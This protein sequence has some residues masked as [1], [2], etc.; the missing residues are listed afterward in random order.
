MFQLTVVRAEGRDWTVG[1]ALGGRERANVSHVA[2]PLTGALSSAPLLSSP[3]ERNLVKEVFR[4]ML[5]ES[6]I[7]VFAVFLEVLV[8]YINVYQEDLNGWLF[9]LLLRL[10]HKQGTDMLSSVHR[11][12]DKTLE[13]IR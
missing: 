2:S 6:H 1:A 12:L 4:R 8:K 9:K 5:V 11:K 7:K 13:C 3:Q 10:L